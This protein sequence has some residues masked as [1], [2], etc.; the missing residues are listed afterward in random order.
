LCAVHPAQGIGQSAGLE[1]KD[2]KLDLMVVIPVS[3][4]SSFNNLSNASELEDALREISR[5]CYEGVSGKLLGGDPPI[6]QRVAVAGY[7]R[8]GVILQA[9]FT[10]T[11]SSSN[12]FR[13]RLKEVYAF[14]IMLD[15]VDGKTKQVLKTKQQGYDELWTKL[16]AWQ[17]DDSDKKIRLYSAE[18]ATVANIYAELKT[19]LKTYGGGYHNDSVKFS[20]FNGTSMSPGSASYSGLT[21]GYE[22]YSTDNSRSLAVLPSNNPLVYLSSENIKNPNGFRT[23]GDYAPNLEGHSWFVSRLFSHAL[24][25]SGF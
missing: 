25:H 23:G 19:R 7:S 15:V 11:R 24:F 10:D 16:K 17:G 18:P 14:D 9:L 22:I 8:S 21:D 5:R 6:L 20:A 12:F 1:D 4:P 13:D 2:S 3:S